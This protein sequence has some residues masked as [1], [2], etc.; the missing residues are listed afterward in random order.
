MRLMFSFHSMLPAHI[1][2]DAIVRAVLP[3]SDLQKSI[4]GQVRAP[5][6]TSRAR[7]A[8]LAISFD[9]LTGKGFMAG[10]IAR[11]GRCRESSTSFS[12][13]KDVSCISS[14]YA[15][16]SPKPNPPANP[17]SANSLRFGNDG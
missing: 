11:T 17:P 9:V 1:S 4:L 16:T 2:S 12:D 13:R 10:I 15:R 8:D 3:A 5:T 14:T 6:R 7:D